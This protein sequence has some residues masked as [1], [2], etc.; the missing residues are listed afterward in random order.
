MGSYR[1]S[2]QSELWWAGFHESPRRSSGG[3]VCGYGR[4]ALCDGVTPYNPS[5]WDHGQIRQIRLVR[6]REHYISPTDG[7]TLP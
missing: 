2:A 6:P 5:T 7:M 3:G 1:C 4:L